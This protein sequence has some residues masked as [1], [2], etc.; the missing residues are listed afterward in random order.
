MSSRSWE[1]GK[2]IGGWFMKGCGWC[3][4][5]GDVDMN[6]RGDMKGREL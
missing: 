4:E 6:E 3:G 1:R 5:F 2:G